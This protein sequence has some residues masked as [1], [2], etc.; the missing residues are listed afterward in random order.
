MIDTLKKIRPK[1][2]VRK[3]VYDADYEALEPLL[4]LAADFGIAVVIVHHTRK[5]PGANLL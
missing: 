4:P 2:D 1:T 3:G 5:T